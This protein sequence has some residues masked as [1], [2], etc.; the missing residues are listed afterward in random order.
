MA[1][2]LLL[3][4]KPRGFESQDSS[5]QLDLQPETL[6]QECT[7]PSMTPF[8][9]FSDPGQTRKASGP[10]STAACPAPTEDAVP[11]CHPD[12][13]ETEA[14]LAG[15]RQEPEEPAPEGTGVL[16]DEELECL[17]G[18]LRRQ[19]EEAVDE[20]KLASAVE[21]AVALMSGQE[22]DEVRTRR[23]LVQLQEEQKE[24]RLRSE[25]LKQDLRDLRRVNLD[26]RRQL[27]ALKPLEV[28]GLPGSR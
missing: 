12:P 2:S 21:R 16:G 13:E 22:D 20:G 3:Q 10:P 19:L 14:S 1:S 24:L 23:E 27:M 18:S 28:D 26:L 25:R 4:Q 9:V 15:Q 11:A 5:T 17:R 8:E 6:Q 7:V